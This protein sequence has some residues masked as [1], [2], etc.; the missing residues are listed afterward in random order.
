[1]RNSK[2]QT[3]KPVGSLS[4]KF[5]QAQEKKSKSLKKGLLLVRKKKNKGEV[6]NHKEKMKELWDIPK[7]SNIQIIG[8]S[9]GELQVEGIENLLKQKNSFII[10]FQ[11]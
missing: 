1:M 9:G 8:K 3:E 6:E 2:G 4:N 10:I 5:D 7:K 11:S